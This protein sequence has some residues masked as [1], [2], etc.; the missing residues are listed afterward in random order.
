MKPTSTSKPV[1]RAICKETVSFRVS[2]SLIT[3][4][5]FL[6][7]FIA[8]LRAMEYYRGILFLTTNRVGLI[9]DAIMS[10]VHLVVK[11]ETLKAPAQT[12]IWT[13]FVQKLQN[14]RIDFMVD[15][16]ATKYVQEFFE[17]TDVSWNGRE[18]RNGKTNFGP[19]PCIALIALGRH[20]L[21]KLTNFQL[22]K[23]QSPLPNTKP[24][25][26]AHQKKT[27][28]SRLSTFKRSS[29]CRKCSKS[30]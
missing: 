2:A 11:Y 6:T 1:P 24:R 17:S 20:V 14:D 18:I 4:Y 23:P 30:T 26:P 15:R 19:Y 29:R 28:S 25:P 27:S 10:R 16:R 7:V 12:R 13:Q 5:S 21:A 22:F 3:K 8:F 9:D